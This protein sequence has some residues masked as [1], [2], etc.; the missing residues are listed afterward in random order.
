[1]GVWGGDKC[2][3]KE[4]DAVE[5]SEVMGRKF[6]EHHGKEGCEDHIT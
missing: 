1:M 6:L 5:I 3:P 2:S 4:E